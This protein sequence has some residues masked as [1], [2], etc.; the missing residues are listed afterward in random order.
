MAARKKMSKTQLMTEL[1]RATGTNKE[2]AAAFV[3]ALSNIAYREAK[4]AGEFTIP[5]VGKM[6]KNK[7]VKKLR[8]L[9]RDT[10]IGTQVGTVMSIR[11]IKDSPVRGK[12]SR[13][14]IR[15]AVQAVARRHGDT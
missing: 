3:E 15:A 1:A 4:K 6:V 2:T 8:F 5:G 12:F 14:K 13:R 10:N 9:N 11:E 7:S